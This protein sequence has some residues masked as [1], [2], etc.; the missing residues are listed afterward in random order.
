MN[1]SAPVVFIVDDDRS[2]LNA[3]SRLLRSFGLNTAIYSSPRLFLEQFDHCFNSCLVLDVDMPFLNGMELQQELAARGSELPVIFLTGHG[4][5]P[6]SVRAMKQGAA[7]FLTKP[8]DDKTLIEA[9]NA[10]LE[11]N[12]LTRENL[13][14]LAVVRE[15]LITLTPREREVLAHVI[16]GRLNKQIAADLGTVEKTVKVHR[17]NMMVKLKVRT[18]ADLV[19]LADKAGIKAA[20]VG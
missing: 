9:I 18:L 14:E 1:P 7:D 4:D 10:A 13:A 20:A 17:A 8:V 15:R 5:I 12:R 6:M 11:K 2:L 3:L 16:A 19:R